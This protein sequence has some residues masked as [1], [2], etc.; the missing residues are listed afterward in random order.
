MRRLERPEIPAVSER[1]VD[2]QHRA[3]RL[4]A[5]LSGDDRIPQLSETPAELVAADLQWHV[6][7]DTVASLDDAAITVAIATSVSH[8]GCVDIERLI[9]D[10][11]HLRRGLGRALVT[12]AAPG[13]ATVMTGRDNTPARLLYEG[14]G[15]RHVRV[16]EVIDGL[17][18]SASAPGRRRS[19]APS[20]APSRVWRQR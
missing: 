4:E 6:V 11:S 2:L 15:F 18:I 5:D 17:W 7:I 20:P 10:P 16:H 3:Y 12:A 14:L 1:L 19:S 13:S 8:S 9:V